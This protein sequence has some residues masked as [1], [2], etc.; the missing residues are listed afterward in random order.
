MASL[1]KQQ[2]VFELSFDSKSRRAAGKSPGHYSM[3][4]AQFDSQ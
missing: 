1:G 2:E 4:T 3:K